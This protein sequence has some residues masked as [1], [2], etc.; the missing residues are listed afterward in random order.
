MRQ[1][2]KK[3]GNKKKPPIK[4]KKKPDKTQLRE[5]KERTNCW[6]PLALAEP[7]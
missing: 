4:R 1:K 7:L 5:K 3:N 2:T 6:V